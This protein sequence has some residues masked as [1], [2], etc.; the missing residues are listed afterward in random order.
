MRRLFS[1]TAAALL[2]TSALAATLPIVGSYG[3]AYGCKVLIQGDIGADDKD[4]TDDWML[5]TPTE[6]MGHEWACSYRSVHGT[7][8]TVECSEAGGN[9]SA[10]SRLTMVENRAVGTLTY[11]D[12]TFKATLHACR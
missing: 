2:S 6:V 9:G 4:W 1:F 10:T 7:K 12:G 8:V 11:K 5:V 3:D